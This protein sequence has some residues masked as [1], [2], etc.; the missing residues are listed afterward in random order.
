MYLSM[1][2]TK[3]YSHPEYKNVSQFCLFNLFFA[4]VMFKM[5]Q[6]SI[7]HPCVFVYFMLVDGRSEKKL[8]KHKKYFTKIKN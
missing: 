1:L 2:V 3:R 8:N 5:K 7:L 4:H 6:K